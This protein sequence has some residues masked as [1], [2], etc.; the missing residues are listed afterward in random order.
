MPVYVNGVRCKALRD[1]G[2]FG[3]VI[4]DKSRVAEERINY[5]KTVKCT[6]AF[7]DPKPKS[8]PTA[9]IKLSSPWFN[10]M[11][12]ILVTAAVTKLPSGLSCILGNSF[13]KDHPEVSDIIQVTNSKN[14]QA[15]RS[16]ATLETKIAVGHPP[17][18]SGNSMSKRRQPDNVNNPIQADTNAAEERSTQSLTADID[19]RPTTSRQRR[20]R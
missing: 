12:D 13:Y 20:H 11:G 15:A 7:D 19:K 14:S 16:N 4:V 5:S 6:G 1:S 18:H 3:P 2:N 17:G 8:I 9:K 10:T